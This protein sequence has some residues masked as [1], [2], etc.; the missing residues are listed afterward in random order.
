MRTIMTLA[1]VAGLLGGAAAPTEAGSFAVNVQVESP[2]RHEPDVLVLPNSQAVENLG[3]GF[4]SQRLFR[5][6]VPAGQTYLNV[7]TH[8][9]W[10]D[11]DL[12]L[13]AG[14]WPSHD[15]VR[16]VSKNGG[17]PEEITIYHPTPGWWYGVLQ[18]AGS[19]GGVDL[20]ASWWQSEY[21][22]H[23]QY[24]DEPFV[25]TSSVVYKPVRVVWHTSFCRRP[26]RGV[27]PGTLRALYRIHHGRF[28]RWHPHRPVHVYRHGFRKPTVVYH[29]PG[30]TVIRRGTYYRRPGTVVVH[31]GR[32]GHRRY[33][34]GHRH[35]D[36]DDDCD[37]DDDDHH[38]GRYHHGRH[39]DDDDDRYGRYRGRHTTGGG[40]VV[41]H[42]R[43][44]TVRSPKIGDLIK[45]HASSSDRASSVPSPTRRTSTTVRR[46]TTTT[47]RVIRPVPRPSSKTPSGTVGGSTRSRSI[48]TLNRNPG[49]V[50]RS[51]GSSARREA[52][53][54]PTAVPLRRSTATRTRTTTPTPRPT[55]SRTTTRT[56]TSTRSRRPT[57][58][59]PSRTRARPTPSRTVPKA[60]ARPAPSVSRSRTR[61][62][63]S[64][65]SDRTSGR[66]RLL[67]RMRNMA[68]KK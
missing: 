51:T 46:T 61:T 9:G 39:D 68:K 1:A 4:G 55:P 36:D 29:R 38:R 58:A 10:G 8:G 23:N 33:P 60:T 27:I 34:H 44:T 11:V 3:G 53:K 57:V 48:T 66:Q 26:Y 17:T 24:Y 7:V 43:T 59:S 41:H 18:G 64:S 35:H 37:W 42:R 20:L 62:P 63:A 31:H 47:P 40:T 19:F 13:A 28:R 5:F 30:T 21:L 67:E 32:Y 65:G 14:Q 56:R 22:Y 16:Y 54:A 15:A 45:P 49:R 52:S 2:Y 50:I 25:K 12:Y 6:Y